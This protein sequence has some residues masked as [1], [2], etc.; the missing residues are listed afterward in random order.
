MIWNLCLVAIGGFFGACSRYVI[1]MFCNSRFSTSF[2]YGTLVVN[3]LGSFLLGI[4]IGTQAQEVYLFLLGIGFLGAFTTFST[5]NVEIVHLAA[6][7]KW[8][9]ILFYIVSTYIIGIAAAFL[10]FILGT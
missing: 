6:E 9:V 1:S 3:S 7:K 8:K 5:L 10:G 2:P 4:L